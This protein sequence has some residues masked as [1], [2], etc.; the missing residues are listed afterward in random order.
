MFLKNIRGYPIL[1]YS[2]LVVLAFLVNLPIISM[3][4]TAL[5]SEEAALASP[6]FFPRSIDLNS[7]FYVWQQTNFSRHVL[8]S[9]LVSV[10]VTL[11]CVVIASLA[12][13]AL[14]RFQGGFM[15][16]YSVMLLLIQMFPW[17]LLLIPLFLIFRRLNLINTLASV[18]VAYTALAL[19]FS[20]WMLK[21]FFDTIPFS[22]EESAMIDGCNQ[23]QSFMRIIIP[24]SLPGISAVA[25]FTFIFSWKEYLLASVFLRSSET[26]TIT[27]GLQQF[28]SQFTTDWSSLMTASTIATVP[29]LILILVAQKYLVAGLTAGATKG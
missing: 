11:G 8:N 25:I 19:P 10:F 24:L 3:I 9:L 12:G 27:V 1:K 26:K 7:F 18:V 6:T 17:V 5:K 23:F 28:V 15:D 14:S 29:I 4:N 2:S 13:Y 20:I 21:A 22:I 16:L